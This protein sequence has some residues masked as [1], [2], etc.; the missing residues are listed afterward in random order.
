MIWLSA[1]SWWACGEGPFSPQ[2]RQR[3]E[4]VERPFGTITSFPDLR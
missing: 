2:L 1:A 3:R 4:A